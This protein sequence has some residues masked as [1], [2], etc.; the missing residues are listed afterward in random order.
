MQIEQKPIDELNAELTIQLE[1]ADYQERFETA[2]RNY[3]KQVQMPG[4]RP[5]HVPASLIRKRFGKALL[6]EEINGLVQRALSGYI[7]SN[8]LPVLGGPM[9]IASGEKGDWDDPREFTFS[10]A[11][12]LAPQIDITLDSGLQFTYHVVAV[13]DELIDRELRD[14]QRRYG[15]MSSTEVSGPDDLLVVSLAEL[16]S[17]GE[18]KTGGLTGKTT[19]TISEVKDE[20]FRARLIGLK[21]DDAADAEPHLITRDHEELARMLGTTHEAIHHLNGQLRITVQEVVHIE[22]AELNQELWDK[23]FPAGEIQTVEE[24]RERV[25]KNLDEMFRRDS[26][27]FFS[28]SVIRE[29]RS[30]FA[31]TLPDAFLKRWIA[32]TSENPMNPEELDYSY[33]MYADTLRVQLIENAI[34]RK[35]D[36]KVSM[37]E[38]LEH[39]KGLYRQQFASYGIPVEEDRLDEMARKTLGKE[40]EARRIYE[41]L[42]N[43]KIIELIRTNCTVEEKAHS[44]EEFTHLVQHG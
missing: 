12:G 24:L 2:L 16:D 25:R 44:L 34:I 36:L 14:Y 37:E 15:K 5:G 26:D 30:R 38:A 13:N 6:A 18:V 1:P 27:W 42:F 40:E 21:K 31:V 43:G 17:S 8:N 23:V 10:F 9:P 39:V 19:I 22:P 41:R 29:L 11:L 28:Q 20:A 32:E 3:R 35:Y 33:P 7:S 4:F